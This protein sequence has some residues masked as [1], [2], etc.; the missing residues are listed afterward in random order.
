MFA[1]NAALSGVA[2]AGYTISQYLARLTAA[3]QARGDISAEKAADDAYLAV[4]GQISWLLGCVVLLLAI[5][6]HKQAHNSAND[7]RD[8]AA[9]KRFTHAWTLL[10]FGGA[11]L[12]LCRCPCF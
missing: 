9:S 7:S 10:S 3:R 4:C 8:A 1:P 2:I 12:S 11:L 5:I 6:T